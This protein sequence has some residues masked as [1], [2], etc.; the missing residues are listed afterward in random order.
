[1]LF[2]ADRCESTSFQSYVLIFSEK[3]RCIVVTR[4][5]DQHTG[6]FLKVLGLTKTRKRHILLYSISCVFILFSSVVESLTKEMIVANINLPFV[7]R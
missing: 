6:A 7:A 5:A 1:M 2:G 3:I 4:D